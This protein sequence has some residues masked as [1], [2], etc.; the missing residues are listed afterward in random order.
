MMNDEER[1]TMIAMAKGIDSLREIVQ[2]AVEKLVPAATA[3]VQPTGGDMRFV[4]TIEQNNKDKSQRMK[5]NVVF[6]RVG[7]FPYEAR[8]RTA[9]EFLE[10][11]HELCDEYRVISLSGGYERDARPF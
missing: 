10:D 9:E 1:K 2:T 3:S 8:M 4:Q 11:L 5:F 6:D 7:A